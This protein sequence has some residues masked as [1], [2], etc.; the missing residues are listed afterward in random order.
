MTVEEKRGGWFGQYGG[1]TTGPWKTKQAAKYAALGSFEKARK[2]ERG[3]LE[4][5]MFK[6][7]MAE[8]A[9]GSIEDV[10]D[11]LRALT[12]EAQDMGLHD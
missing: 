11:G 3:A 2:A 12:R 9:G 1:Q 8:R 10:E 5:E 4:P 6:Q 7:V